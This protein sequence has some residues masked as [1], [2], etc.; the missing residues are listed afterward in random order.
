MN[1]K[2]T[3]NRTILLK[4]KH[5]VNEACAGIQSHYET[6]N[7][8]ETDNLAERINM[9]GVESADCFHFYVKIQTFK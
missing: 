5:V 3:N 6:N 2:Q 7:R 8:H 1:L 4:F 9:E